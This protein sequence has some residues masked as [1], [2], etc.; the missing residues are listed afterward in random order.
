M[1]NIYLLRDGRDVSRSV[2]KMGWAGNV[3]DAADWWINAENE[4]YEMQPLLKENQYIEMSFE[5]IIT[6]TQG[7]LNRICKFIGTEYSDIM[8]DYVKNS[9][10]S[11]PDKKL[12]FQWK[13]KLS[14]KQLQHVDERIGGNLE[15]R[16]FE[17]SGLPK[18][19]LSSF[20]KTLLRLNS[21]F[22]KFIYRA[23]TYGVFLVIKDLIARRLGLSDWQ[24]KLQLELNQI[25]DSNLK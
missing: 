7:E 15:I 10:Y 13:N 6:D 5:N 24:K 2:M 14:N 19:H 3:W 18:I 4:W 16:G 17:L 23:R 25:T 21:H 20:Q 9:T 1:Q 8:L 22:G 12:I 11:L